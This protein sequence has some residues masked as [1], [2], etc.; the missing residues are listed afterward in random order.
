MV[1]ASCS[2]EHG[3]GHSYDPLDYQVLGSCNGDRMGTPT[4]TVVKLLL[5]LRV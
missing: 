5:N 2:S 1:D 3:S 4:C